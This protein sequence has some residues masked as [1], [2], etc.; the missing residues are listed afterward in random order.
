MANP[1]QDVPDSVRVLAQQMSHPRPLRRGS[2]GERYLKCGKPN[3]ACATRD[4]ARHGPYFSLTRVVGGRTQS[5]RLTAAQAERVREQLAA[6]QEFRRQ[7]EAYWEASEGWAEAE[8]AE[9]TAA[10]TAEKRGSVGAS[11]KSSVKRSRSLPGRR[12]PSA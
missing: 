2:L 1:A 3:C 11:T 5:R 8:L 9:V 7:V 12:R 6:G 4:D 10:E